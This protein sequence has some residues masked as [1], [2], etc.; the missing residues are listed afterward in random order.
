MAGDAKVEMDA[1]FADESPANNPITGQFRGAIHGLDVSDRT[2]IV[3]NEVVPL[4]GNG[5]GTACIKGD[6]DD[7]VARGAREKSGDEVRVEIGPGKLSV[8]GLRKR[9]RRDRREK[10]KWFDEG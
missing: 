6:V 9:S 2:F 7:V 5:E 4:E 8:E 1:I 3:L 10:A